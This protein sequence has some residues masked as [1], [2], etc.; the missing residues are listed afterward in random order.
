[1]T[2][3]IDVQIEQVAGCEDTPEL[4]TRILRRLR[5]EID[6][7]AARIAELQAALQELYDVADDVE[8]LSVNDGDG[9]IDTMQS[10]TLERACS[11]ALAALK[12]EA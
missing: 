3:G 6:A 10:R 9:Y 1:M 5:A 11:K 4:A 12:K 7:Q 2:T 8:D